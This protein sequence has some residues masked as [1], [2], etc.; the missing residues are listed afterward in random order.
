MKERLNEVVT[1]FEKCWKELL[2]D[3]WSENKLLNVYCSEGDI[4]LHLASKLL[5]KMPSSI[6]VHVEFPISLEIEDF[7]TEMFWLGKPKRKRKKGESIVA[8][9][10]VR[11]PDITFPLIIAEVKYSPYPINLTTIIKAT[12]GKLEEKSIEIIKKALRKEVTNLR[13]REKYG[14]SQSD[15]LWYLDEGKK[16]EKIIQLI[17]DLKKK[18]NH[19]AYVYY[20]VIDE[21]YPDL[22]QKLEREVEK[23]N[24][25]NTFRLRCRYYPV[26]KWMEEQVGKL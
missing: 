1:I 10:V 9:I 23:Y 3:Y 20:C 16:V 8:D 26:R 14:P 13:E 7:E 22:K 15:I 12:E 17:Q 19:D 24:P 18:H 21:F 11:D 5:E 4:Q 6:C 2:E 25:P